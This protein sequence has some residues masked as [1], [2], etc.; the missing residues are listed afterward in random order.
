VSVKVANAQWLRA[1][2]ALFFQGQD[3]VKYRVLVD[4][5]PGARPDAEW[6]GVEVHCRGWSK[7]F[8]IPVSMVDGED[9]RSII[10]ELTTQSEGGLAVSETEIQVMQEIIH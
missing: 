1:F 7:R 8:R 9:V 5:W 3:D 4:G 10:G 2:L 6:I